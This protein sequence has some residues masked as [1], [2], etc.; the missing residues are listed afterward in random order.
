MKTSNSFKC[1][2]VA[3]VSATVL[4]AGC[5]VDTGGSSYFSNV[6]LSSAN[7]DAGIIKGKVGSFLSAHVA[8]QIGIGGT[9]PGTL[10]I[11]KSYVTDPEYDIFGDDLPPGL[12][13]DTSTGTLKGVPS[14]PGKWVLYPAVRDKIR[15]DNTYNG[16]GYWWTTEVNGSTGKKWTRSKSATVID[17]AN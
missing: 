9:A 10:V 11:I 8:Y 14:A 17:I 2:L 16:N 1:L 3:A 6:S 5:A 7:L 15:G 4:L 12:S 13:W